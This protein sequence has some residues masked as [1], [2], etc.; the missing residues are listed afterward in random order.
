MSENGYYGR[1]VVKPPAWTDLIPLYFFAGGMA[2][3]AATLGVAERIAGNE[4]LARTMILGA[5]AGTAL[6]TY[7]LIA[8]L[9]R[10]E[11]FLNMV[12]HFNPT[13]P[14]SV[15]V[16]IFS[17]FTGSVFFAAGSELTGVAKPAGRFFATIAGLIGP[18]MSVYTSVLVGNTVM[19]AW[20]L[21]RTTLPALFAATSASSAGAWGMLFGPAR[22]SGSARRLAMLGGTATVAA[23][24]AVYQELGPVQVEP[25]KKGEA[26]ALAR[27]ARILNIGGM[28]CASFAKKSDTLGRVAGALLLAGGLA[29]RFAVYRAGCASAKDPKYTIAAQ[30][31]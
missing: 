22:K 5:A 25:Y 29:E 11:R 17:A 14:M 23:L 13:S 3:T 28:V 4:R 19:P 30:A 12:K 15:G 9:R 10:P 16:Y 26:G 6:S 24:Q 1:P 27:T 20:H 7:C 21:P 2:G 8:D 18:M 31:K